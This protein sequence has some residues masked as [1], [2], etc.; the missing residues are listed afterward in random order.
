MDLFWYSFD[1]IYISQIPDF[2]QKTIKNTSETTINE[3]IS[4]CNDNNEHGNCSLFWAKTTLLLQ[5]VECQVY[6]APLKSHSSL[7]FLVIFIKLMNKKEEWHQCD[8]LKLSKPNTHMLDTHIYF[9]FTL[10]QL[11][12]LRDFVLCLS[13][14]S[15]MTVE[16]SHSNDLL[17]S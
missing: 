16:D 1:F 17:F 3:G 10:N 13:P 4:H 2:V 5:S 12:R 8:L 15:G 7:T 6:I 14:P 9:L 11:K